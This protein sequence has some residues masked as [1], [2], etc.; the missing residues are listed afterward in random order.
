VFDS[1]VEA[2]FQDLLTTARSRGNGPRSIS[3]GQLLGHVISHE[4][5]HV[6]LNLEVHS[7]NGIMRGKW[8]TREYDDAIHGR[9]LFTSEQTQILQSEVRRRISMQEAL[10]AANAEP[11]ANEQGTDAA[12]GIDVARVAR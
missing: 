2:L 7:A 9:L 10:S 5:G 8:T 6:L 1:N 11:S 12:P 3:K 4:L